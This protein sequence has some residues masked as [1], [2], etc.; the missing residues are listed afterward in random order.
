MCLDINN[1][2][3]FNKRRVSRDRLIINDIINNYGLQIKMSDYSC[4]MFSHYNLNCIKDNNVFF[5][6]QNLSLDCF[7]ELV[8][9]NFNRKY[10]SDVYISLEDFVVVSQSEFIGSSHRKITKSIYRRKKYEEL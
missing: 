6:E 8:V 4:K 2:L 10:P 5:I 3:L 7:D 1:G 9:Y